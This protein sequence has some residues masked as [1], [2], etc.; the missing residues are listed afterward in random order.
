MGAIRDLAEGFWSGAVEPARFW[1][2]T[3]QV[4]ELATGVFFLHTF[5]N[6]TVV[7]TAAGLVL[8]DTSNYAARDRTFGLVRSVD[9]APVFAAIYTHGHADHALGLPPF[10]AEARERGWPRPRIVG[11]RN[12]AARFARYRRTNAFNALIN[13][14]QFGIA[15]AWPMDY[16]EPDMVYDDTLAFAAGDLRLELRHARGETDDH[17]WVWWPERRIL[18]TGDQFIWVA[19]NAGNPQKVQ[20]Y[21]GEWAASLRAMSRLEPE[22]LIPGHGVPII[23]RDRVRQALDETAEWLE[24]LERDTVA[25]MNAG[26]TLDTV[27]A[28]VRPLPHLARRPYLQAVYDEPEYVV[29]NIWRLYGGWWDGVPSHLKPARE[30]EIG[31]EVARLAGGVE[32]LVARAQ[33]LAAAGDL[34]LASHLIDWAVAAEP[35][36]RGVHAARAVIYEA[37]AK[38]AGALMTRGIFSAAARESAARASPGA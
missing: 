3:G 34:A 26:A 21:A 36:G 27:L 30:A 2:P 6:M 18:W 38:E 15:P 35:E 19:P 12:V 23:G 37:R 11:H 28:E 13:A 14:R 25:R 24:A 5:A 1:K 10:L 33:E 32:R 7:R 31:R 20:R 8:I 4:E 9:P 16:D 29:R 17:T 22:L